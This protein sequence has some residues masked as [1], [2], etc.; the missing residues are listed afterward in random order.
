MACPDELTLELWLADA[1]SPGETTSVAEHVANCDLCT[2]RLEAARAVSSTLKTAL[3]LDRDEHAYLASL[4]LAAAWRASSA[5]PADGRW[6][7][8][9]LIGVVGAFVVWTLALQ[10]FG[11]VL[12]IA[13]LVGLSTV[14]VSTALGLLLGFGETFIEISTNPALGLSQPLLA[15]LA[16]ALLFWPRI[17]AA[18]HYF[19]GVRS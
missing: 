11:D 7:W 16:L 15:V 13:N 2:T 10:P 8:V 19:Q 3:E 4:D 14:V 1:L 9:A 6:G 12:A 18:P 17:K 5:S